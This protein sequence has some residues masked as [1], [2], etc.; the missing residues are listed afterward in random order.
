MYSKRLLTL[1]ICGLLF[2]NSHAQVTQTE[3]DIHSLNLFNEANWKALQTYGKENISAGIDFPLLRMRTGYAAFMLNNFSEAIKQYDVV[4]KNDSYNNIA[5]YYIYLCRKYLN[6]HELAAAELKYL[7]K[8]VLQ[9]EKL[10]PVAFTN[11]GIEVSYKQ[12]D[13]YARGNPLYTRLNLG[14]RFSRN[15]H[16][17]Q[18]VAS[19]KQTISEPLFLAV[20]NNNNININEVA[21]YNRLMLNLDSRWQIKGAYHFLYTPFNNFVYYNHLALLGVKYNGNY[22]DIQADAV[23]GTLIDSTLQQYNVQLRLYPFGNLNLYSFSTASLRQQGQS[24]F[25]F[26]QVLGAKIMKNIWLEGNV[27]LGTFSNL[28]ENDA[29]Y[30]YNSIDPNKFKGGITT[31]ISLSAK[32]IVQLGYTYELRELYKQSTTFNQHSFNTA[33][34]WKF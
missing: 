21:Y 5:H 22:F 19:Y 10:K 24:A 32:T 13:W 12:T 29:L 18:S 7:S 26:R 4:L 25:N 20:S 11:I 3:A 31:Y 2:Y 33:I 15:F 28:I 8:E 34:S 6:Q 23:V 14:N 30:V 27:T 16:M 17:Q 1:F 9:Q